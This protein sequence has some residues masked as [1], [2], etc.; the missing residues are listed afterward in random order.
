MPR[1][2]D[3]KHISN[4]RFC[5]G[6]QEK[7]VVLLI[8]A[9]QTLHV[10]VVAL[11]T[12]PDP[13]LM[14][15]CVGGSSCANRLP[16]FIVNGVP[17]VPLGQKNS[18]VLLFR[19]VTSLSPMPAAVS[20]AV[21]GL[22]CKELVFGLVSNLRLQLRTQQPMAS[23]VPSQ[24]TTIPYHTMAGCAEN[25]RSP[26]RTQHSHKSRMLRHFI[27]IKVGVGVLL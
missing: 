13:Q 19:W 1:C 7:G 27:Q 14:S 20:H 25:W 6:L 26:P 17:N 16:C 12:C 11:H 15:G 8:L 3:A 9:V 18:M 24:T 23:D 10:V 21:L 22:N 4:N 2:W 5:A